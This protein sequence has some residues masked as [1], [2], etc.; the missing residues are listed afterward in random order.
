[1]DWGDLSRGF[2]GV[3]IKRLSSHEVDP[4]TS[5]GHEFQGARNLL[6]LLGDQ[7]RKKWP[8]S[9]H[10]IADDGASPVVQ[11]TLDSYASWYDVRKKQD[12][13]PEW[14]LY[15]PAETNAIRDLS[16]P[17][18]LLLIALRDNGNLAVFIAP[19]DSV[20]E[21]LLVQAFGVARGHYSQSEDVKWLLAEN[22]PSLDFVTAEAFQQLSLTLEGGTGSE[23]LSTVVDVSPEAVVGDDSEVSDV[24]SWMIELWPDRIK[25]KSREIVERVINTCD[26]EGHMPPDTALERWLEVAEAA[27]RIWEKTSACR[28]LAPLRHDSDVTD[29]ELVERLGSRWMSFR[30]S[31]VSRAGKVMEEF[32]GILFTRAGLAFQTGSLAKT[33]NGKLPDFL[34]PDGASY[35][36]L[37]FPPER[38][39]ILGSKTSFKDRWRQIL[40][41]G[42]RVSVKHGVTRDPLITD[43]MLNQMKKSGLVVVM[44]KPIIDRC[45]TQSSNIVSLAEFISEVHDLQE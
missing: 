24:A 25:G 14:R 6:T 33:E 2:K 15:Y 42:D 7:E 28:F 5:R 26:P 21:A 3:A 20:S 34:F 43:S 36:N 29:L 8:T 40:S 37:E 1:M 31:R 27:Y 38:L 11:L 39:R 4:N 18:D 19:R 30:Q 12:R 45:Q 44:P 16:C 23:S 9:Y 32:L 13:D 10:F 41:E 22:A 35:H 17:G